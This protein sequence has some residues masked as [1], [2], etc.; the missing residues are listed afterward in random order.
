MLSVA[1]GVAPDLVASRD[2]TGVEDR[3]HHRDTYSQLAPLP[4][5]DGI[6]PY[7]K[8]LLQADGRVMKTSS[9]NQ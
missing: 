7:N 1:A 4:G 2:F 3:T 9:G 5:H 8:G 6:D